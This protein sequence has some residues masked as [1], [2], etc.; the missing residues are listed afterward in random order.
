LST[1][2]INFQLRDYNPRTETWNTQDPMGYVD[3][4]NTYQFVAD[5]PI[6]ARD[7]TGTIHV[8]TITN[9]PSHWGSFES[10]A[11]FWLNN[12]A[13]KGG[14]YIVQEVTIMRTETKFT[15]LS[16]FTTEWGRYWE[17]WFVQGGRR[18][19]H[20]NL[21]TGF[22]DKF[23]GPP[24]KG[25]YGEITVS[26]VLKFFSTCGTLGDPFATPKV[27]PD[28]GSGFKFGN[29]PGGNPLSGDLPSTP[30]M[31]PKT[32][33]TEPAWWNSGA[34][35]GEKAASRSLSL[36]WYAPLVDND[37]TFSGWDEQGRRARAGKPI[38]NPRLGQVG[39]PYVE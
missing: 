15:D 4:M 21:S 16:H 34:D 23:R 30:V 5:S 11:N 32:P 3:G 1:G 19:P 31:T 36:Q 25:T 39:L 2:L 12:P 20:S 27:Q 13:P 18:D 38:V 14:G 22:T 8:Q 28:P 26:G 29:S 6:I 10:K 17:A 24:Q 9:E 7:A 37:Q 33:S 35:V